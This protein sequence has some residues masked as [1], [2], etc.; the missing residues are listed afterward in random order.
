MTNHLIPQDESNAADGRPAPSL[1]P[2]L[3]LING[4]IPD[5]VNFKEQ[6]PLALLWQIA[7]G[8]PANRPLQLVAP[9]VPSTQEPVPTKMP[10]H[11]QVPNEEGA[12]VEVPHPISWAGHMARMVFEVACGERPSPQ[13]K[14]WVSPDQ[15][16]LLSLRGQSFSRHPATRAQKGLSRLRKV[17]GVQAMQVA[18]GIIEASAVIVGSARSHAIALRM[19]AIGNQWL[20]TAIE[21]R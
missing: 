4:G 8:L 6:L 11:I 15:L 14:R 18:P 16:S 21:M 7:P 20:L 13:L 1:V 5:H 3:T 19:E 12:I 10:S 9:P 2:R 17:R